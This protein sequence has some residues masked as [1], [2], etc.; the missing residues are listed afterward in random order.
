ME[1]KTTHLEKDSPF[2][3]NHLTNWRLTAIEKIEKITDEEMMYSGN[4]SLSKSDFLVI[5][6]EL[7]ASLQRV[8]HTV[9]ESPTEELANLNI[10]FFWM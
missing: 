2:L 8:I 4:F 5:R 6:E 10:D 9:K 7:V 1:G 3:I